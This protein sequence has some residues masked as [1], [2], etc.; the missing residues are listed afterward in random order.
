[1]TAPKTPWRVRLEALLADGE[2]H[3]LDECCA[4]AGPLVPP[5]RAS[6]VSE[7]D[8]RRWNPGPR[9][10][11]RSEDAAVVAG[12]RKIIRWTLLQ[13]VRSGVAVT[14]TDPTRWKAANQG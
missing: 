9:Q 6:R 8:R 1:M 11:P 13:M 12:R 14:A 7:A 4:V 2:W 3:D 10:R 5:G